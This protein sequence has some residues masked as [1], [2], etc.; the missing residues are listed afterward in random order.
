MSAPGC[1]LCRGVGPCFCGMPWPLT[2][3]QHRALERFQAGEDRVS[4]IDVLMGGWLEHRGLI[5]LRDGA[6]A[7]TKDGR[8]A[9]V[10]GAS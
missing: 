9:L 10:G 3:A 1:S 7:I 4:V 8:A 6:Y 2:A 5:A